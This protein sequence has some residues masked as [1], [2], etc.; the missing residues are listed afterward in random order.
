MVTKLKAVNLEK[1]AQPN[2]KFID[3]QYS[4]E[5]RLAIQCGKK[6][7]IARGKKKEKAGK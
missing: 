7:S 5:C 4:Q 2:P 1:E 6:T 3:P